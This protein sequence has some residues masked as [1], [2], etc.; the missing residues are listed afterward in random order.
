VREDTT[1]RCHG[2]MWGGGRNEMMNCWR[3]DQE[4]I[5]DYTVKKKLKII[6]IIIIIKLCLSVTTNLS[7]MIK[8]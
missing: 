7:F 6:I 3:A 1:V 2:R 8:A 5:N 4:G